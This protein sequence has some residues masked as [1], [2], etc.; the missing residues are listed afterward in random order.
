MKGPRIG[1]KR[2][3]PKLRSEEYVG[4]SRLLSSYSFICASILDS[5]WIYLVFFW[6][7]LNLCILRFFYSAFYCLF[8]FCDIIWLLQIRHLWPDLIREV[9][10]ARNGGVSEGGGCGAA[11]PSGN[12]V[13][14]GHQAFRS[15]KALFIVLGGFWIFRLSTLQLSSCQSCCFLLF[16][17]SSRIGRDLRF[18]DITKIVG[19]LGHWLPRWL[20][21][22][23]F[24][25]S[26]CG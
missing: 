4:T 11:T 2:R 7:Q 6:F 9:K 20:C 18:G 3:V 16:C 5:S 24:G 8:L 23:E 17:S 21:R 25:L 12:K 15:I 13:M 22:I 1:P 26:I 10:Y 19:W 14:T